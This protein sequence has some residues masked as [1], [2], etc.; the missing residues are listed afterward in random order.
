MKIT[1]VRADPAGNIT[2]LVTT[3]IAPQDYATVSAY[4]LQHGI[5]QAQQVGFVTAPR[6]GGAVR[7]EMMGGEFCGNALRSTGLY[8]AQNQSM[9]GT[10]SIEVEISGAHWPLTVTVDPVTGFSSAQM[11]IPKLMEEHVF[12][13][14]RYIPV[15]LEGIVHLIC[16]IPPQEIEALDRTM[17]EAC[18]RFRRDAC[19]VIFFDAKSK[20]MTPVVYVAKTSSIV[21]EGSCASGTTALAAVLAY[22]A[23]DGVHTYPIRQP[24]GEITALVRKSGGRLTDISIGGIVHISEQSEWEI[25]VSDNYLQTRQFIEGKS[26][27]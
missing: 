16:D 6:V 7:L 24:G 25:P 17:L 5:V 3:P 8:W 13:G 27:M 23:A 26:G 20:S 11:P 2:A 1:L 10:C 14:R 12:Y 18:E 9:Q 4:I 15:I 19:G 22:H 21:Y